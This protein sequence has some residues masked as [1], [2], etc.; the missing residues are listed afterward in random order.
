MYAE[1][2]LHGYGTPQSSVPGS[3]LTAE[4]ALNI[5]RVRGGIHLS[6][7]LIPQPR[8][9]SWMR[10]FVRGLL[11]L[12]LNHTAGLTCADEYWRRCEIFAENRH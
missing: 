7:A 12:D 10:L 5:V 11:S 2:V 1:A 3:G 9:N 8:K 4:D 6:Q